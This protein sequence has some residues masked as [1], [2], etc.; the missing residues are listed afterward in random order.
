[1]VRGHSG[2]TCAEA[3]RASIAPGEMLTFTDIEN[4]VRQKGD[5]KDETIWQHLMS[6]V[7]NLPPA[8]R[9]WP[10]VMPFLIVQQ[11]G[12]YELYDKKRHP[13]PIE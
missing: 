9:R 2:E 10:S 4:R 12:R 6:V 5:W 8:R 11:D 13:E 1:M 7:V 3:I